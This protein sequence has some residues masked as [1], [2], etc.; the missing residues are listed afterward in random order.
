MFSGWE[1]F[2]LALMGLTEFHFGFQQ[3]G[4]GQ[5]DGP[6]WWILHVLILEESNYNSRYRIRLNIYI[7]IKYAILYIIIIYY[8]YYYLH[9]ILYLCYYLY[10]Y[11]LLYIICIIVMYKYLFT[12]MQ[13]NNLIAYFWFSAAS[14]NWFGNF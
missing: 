7:Y 3:N 12:Y 6:W 11:M 4:R 9:I 2:S 8:L 13:R 14:R 10:D 1:F 5:R